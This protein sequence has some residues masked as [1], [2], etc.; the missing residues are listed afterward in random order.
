MERDDIENSF[1][2]G[3]PEENLQSQEKNDM[4]TTNQCVH[5]ELVNSTLP[6]SLMDGSRTPTKTLKDSDAQSFCVTKKKTCLLFFGSV[7]PPFNFFNLLKLV[8]LALGESE[9]Y[10]LLWKVNSKTC[11]GLDAVEKLAMS[12]K[13]TG[14]EENPK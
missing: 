12:E 4:Q 11:L 8:Q 14:S 13:K 2:S 10:K 7:N 6:T 1:L 3:W 9:V 5:S